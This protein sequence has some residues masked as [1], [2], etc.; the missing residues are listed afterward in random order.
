MAEKKTPAMLI[1]EL[2]KKG[3]KE[4]APMDDKLMVAEEILSFIKDEDAEGLAMALADFIYMCME[5]E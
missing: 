1:I 4:E 2:A 5:K 3:K